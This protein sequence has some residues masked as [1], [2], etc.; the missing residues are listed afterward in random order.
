MA[1]ETTT[2]WLN[3]LI[4]RGED[5]GQCLVILREIAVREEKAAERSERAAEREAKSKE[6]DWELKL[7]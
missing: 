2:D 7:R 3:K 5:I 6:R 4:E 1:R